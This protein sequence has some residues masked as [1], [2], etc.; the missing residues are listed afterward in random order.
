MEAI[1][2]FHKDDHKKIIQEIKQQGNKYFQIVFCSFAFD[3]QEMLNNLTCRANK[4]TELKNR[5]I[6]KEKGNETD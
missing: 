3:Y 6:N 5:I 4:L 1:S 2:D